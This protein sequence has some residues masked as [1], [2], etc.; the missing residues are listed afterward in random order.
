MN[1]VPLMDETVFTEKHWLK[2]R[3]MERKRYTA[4]ERRGEIVIETDDEE[5]E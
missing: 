5:D 1:L 2:L 3:R 4:T